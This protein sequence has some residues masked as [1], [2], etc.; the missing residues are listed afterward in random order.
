MPQ[1]EKHF[2]VEEANDLLP[3][4]RALLAGIQAVRDSLVIEWERAQPVLKAAGHN[5]GG[6][7]ASGYVSD[8]TRLNVKLRE[9]HRQGVVMKDI[10][11][12][13]IDFPHW[14]DDE[15][16]FLCWELSEDRIGYWHELETGYQGR[17][18]I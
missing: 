1:F 14:R 17:K 13:L 2:S 8:L 6:K 12:G 4:L 11:R 18:P 10:D 9:L 3:D 16:V 15:E 7:E 5:G